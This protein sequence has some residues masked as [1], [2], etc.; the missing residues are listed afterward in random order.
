MATRFCRAVKLRTPVQASPLAPLAT[1]WS[2]D[3][4]EGSDF[5]SQYAIAFSSSHGGNFRR[6]VAADDIVTVGRSQRQWA[7]AAAAT[8]R[9]AD[10]FPALEQDV[11][12]AIRIECVRRG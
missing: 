5:T 3:Q 11:L 4:V 8:W 12:T 7:I 2:H 6:L 9:R 1:C 10:L